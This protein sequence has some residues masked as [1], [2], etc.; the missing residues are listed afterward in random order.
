MFDLTTIQLINMSASL[1]VRRGISERLCHSPFSM[2]YAKG[3]LYA[4]IACDHRA[5]VTD[6][7]LTASFPECEQ[8]DKRNR[9]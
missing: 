8:L 2:A 3:Y 9:H 4:N 5:K 6:E 1:N 7:T